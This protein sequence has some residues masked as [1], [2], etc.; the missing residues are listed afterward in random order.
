MHTFRT[1]EPLLPAIQL[2]NATSHGIFS[3]LWPILVLVGT[4]AK[5]VPHYFIPLCRGICNSFHF[6]SMSIW[7]EPTLCIRTASKQA[8]EKNQQPT[9]IIICI[10]FFFHWNLFISITVARTHTAHCVRVSE[11]MSVCTT[12]IDFIFYD[13]FFMNV[14]TKQTFR[15]NIRKLANYRL[16]HWTNGKTQATNVSLVVN[17]CT[18]NTWL[19]FEEQQ[20]SHFIRC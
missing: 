3:L 7:C 17:E 20:S 14:K 4:H 18:K 10:L 1:E 12:T 16:T 11:V 13:L 19:L 2:T 15:I 8:N 6:R 9:K 5:P